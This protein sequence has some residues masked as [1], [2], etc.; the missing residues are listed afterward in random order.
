MREGVFGE[1]GMSCFWVV[2]MDGRGFGGML[3]RVEIGDDD[4]DDDG[5]GRLLPAGLRQQACWT[6]GSWV[7]KGR[8]NMRIG[9]LFLTG[10]S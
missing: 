4:G 9:R 5:G 10:D 2:G 3:S 6:L 1:K 8:A 7:L